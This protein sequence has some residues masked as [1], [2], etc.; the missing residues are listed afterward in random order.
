MSSGGMTYITSSI[1]FAK[2]NKFRGLS[3]RA[4]YT[5]RATVRLS[6]KLVPTFVDRGVLRGQRDESLRP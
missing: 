5:D 2:N 1:K 6:A 3:L 4:N